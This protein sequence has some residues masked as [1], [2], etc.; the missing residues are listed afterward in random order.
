MSIEQGG[1]EQMK[2]MM[3]TR[4]LR[5][6]ITGEECVMRDIYI[7]IFIASIVNVEIQVSSFR[8]TSLSWSYLLSSAKSVMISAF[9]GK[10]S[11]RTIL[12]FLSSEQ[13]GGERREEGGGSRSTQPAG[14]EI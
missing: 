10:Y 11:G 4:S 8:H 3:M 6:N 7:C 2:R 13:E 5:Q 14:V 12:S 9:S 1:M